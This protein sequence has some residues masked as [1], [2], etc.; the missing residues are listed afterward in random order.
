MLTVTLPG[1][2]ATHPQPERALSTAVFTVCGQHILLDCGEGTQLALQRCRI[3][4]MKIDLIALTHYHGDHILG[5]PGLLQ[6][7]GTMGRTSP[8]HITGPEEGHESILSAILTLAGDTGYPVSWL[9]MPREGLSLTQLNSKWP[10]EA[11]FAVFPTQHRIA[12]QGY[13]LR[14]KRMRRLDVG[15]A[16]AMGI[17][18]SLWRTLQN[19]HCAAVDGLEIHPESVCGPERPGLRVVYTGDTAP[20]IPVEEAARSADLLI[21]DATYPDDS[22]ADKAAFY[23]HS[24]FSQTAVLAARAGVKRLW[25]THF[26]AMISRPEDFLSNA[27]KHFS[28]AECGNDGRTLR[29]SFRDDDM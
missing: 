3:N 7:M 29:L 23:G 16:E 28:S 6:M 5:L 17:P 20:C 9:P 14:L 2:G 4:P 13:A 15:R 19:G 8:L 24:T 1:T 22:Y 11:E 25:L 18:R 26:S 21:M 27:Q 12:S 10:P